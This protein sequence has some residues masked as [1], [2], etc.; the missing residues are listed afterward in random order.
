MEE[1]GELRAK[2]VDYKEAI[3][4]KKYLTVE[5]VFQRL[6]EFFK[7]HLSHSGNLKRQIIDIKSILSFTYTVV[8]SH[9]YCLLFTRYLLFLAYRYKSNYL[10]IVFHSCKASMAMR[11]YMA[12]PIIL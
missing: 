1:R 7:L 8:S 2:K 11:A 4:I 12:S 9:A 6:R 5:A 10:V 3:L